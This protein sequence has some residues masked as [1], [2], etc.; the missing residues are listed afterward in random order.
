MFHKIVKNIGLQ[1]KKCDQFIYYI[2]RH[3]E[4][5]GDAHGPAA[6]KMIDIMYR[7]D[8]SGQRKLLISSIRAVKA[9]IKMWDNVLEELNEQK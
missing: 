7:H 8:E 5:D 1:K 2:I 9:R 4:L 6:K 3:I